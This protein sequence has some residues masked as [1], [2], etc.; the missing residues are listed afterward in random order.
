MTGVTIGQS[1]GRNVILFNQLF[2]LCDLIG[3]PFI[4]H[5]KD[6]VNRAQRV[7]G[8]AV[9]LELMAFGEQ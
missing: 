5:V 3:G 1:I 9:T 8:R 4:V 7:F 6:L 2:T